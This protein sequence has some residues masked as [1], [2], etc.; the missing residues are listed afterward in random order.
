MTAPWPKADIETESKSNFLNVRFG[1]ES[2]H[3]VY[4]ADPIT[5]GFPLIL[6]HLFMPQPEAYLG[7]VIRKPPKSS[8]L[9]QQHELG[10]KKWQIA[11]RIEKHTI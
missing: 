5:G 7:S 1:G 6:G 9:K 10:E 2:G 11:T 8:W 4:R 3:R